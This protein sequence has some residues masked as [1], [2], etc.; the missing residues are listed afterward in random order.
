MTDYLSFSGEQKLTTP[1]EDWYETVGVHPEVFGAWEQFCEL[2]ATV[3]PSSVK[4][5]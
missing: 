5:A 2:A 1:F 3:E 4:S